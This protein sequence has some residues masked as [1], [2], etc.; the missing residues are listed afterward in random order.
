MRFILAG[1]TQ[2]VGY[3][4]FAFARIGDDAARTEYTVRADLALIRRYDIRVQELPLLCRALLE[5]LEPADETRDLTFT[6]EDMCVHAKDCAAVRQAAA[7]KKKP[8]HRPP[9][10]NAGAAW[11]GNNRILPPPP[12]AT[13][14]SAVQGGLPPRFHSVGDPIRGPEMK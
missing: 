1:F 12:L 13:G 5:R 3:R 2:D 11:R 7:L 10:E 14:A 6:E 9:T 4:V 8:P